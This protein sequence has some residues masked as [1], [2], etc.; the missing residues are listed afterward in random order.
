MLKV[1][2]FDDL[3]LHLLT[4]SCLVNALPY[5][6]VSEFKFVQLSIKNSI[7]LR[8]ILRSFMLVHWSKLVLSTHPIPACFSSP[9]R[10]TVAPNY[11]SLFKSTG[12]EY[13]NRRL[14]EC[15][16]GY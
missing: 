16:K 10:A 4:N 2:Q 3:L 5:D 13:C 15:V 8:S 12:I 14:S 6:T 7:L 11:L 1:L 9:E